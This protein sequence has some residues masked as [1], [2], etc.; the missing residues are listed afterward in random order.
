MTSGTSGRDLSAEIQTVVSGVRLERARVLLTEYLC[1]PLEGTQRSQPWR[2]EELG[3]ALR[4][5]L[6]KPYPAPTRLPMAGS[7]SAFWTA[8]QSVVQPFPFISRLRS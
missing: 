4:N 5:E 3:E 1:L 8:T 7:P 2:T 6:A